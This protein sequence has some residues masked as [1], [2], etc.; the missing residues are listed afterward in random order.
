MTGIV[1]DFDIAYFR[2]AFPAF[3]NPAAFSDEMLQ[4][5]WDWATYY[6]SD[7]NYGW[8]SNLNSPTNPA[9]PGRSPGYARSRAIQLMMAHLLQ[10]QVLNAAGQQGG[11]VTQ[12][13]VDKVSVGLE[14]PPIPNQWQWWLNGTPYG[15]QLLALLQVKSAGGFYNGGVPVLGAFTPTYGGGFFIW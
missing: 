10:L 15:Q 4:M 2:K 11:I 3:A 9:V 13:T 1:I 5:Y 8:L 14:P 12:A 7:V 6:V